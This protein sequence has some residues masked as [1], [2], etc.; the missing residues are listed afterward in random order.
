MTHRVN[1]LLAAVLTVVGITAWPTHLFAQARLF[2]GDNGNEKINVYDPTNGALVKSINTLQNPQGITVG[3]DNRLYAIDTDGRTPHG[4]IDRY[5][6]DTGAYLA[7]IVADVGA[8]PYD[9]MLGPDGKLYVSLGNGTVS[10]YDPTTG[11]PL[12][13][14]GHGGAAFAVGNQGQLISSVFGPDGNLY[15]SDF[16][17]SQVLRFDGTSG[18]LLGVFVS[19][20]LSSPT[21]LRFGP[22]ANLYVGNRGSN[23][24]TRF[25]GTTGAFIDTFVSGS[26]LSQPETFDFGT[27]GVLYV[28]SYANHSI[29]RYN[30]AT[31]AF[32]DV[33][34]S[35]PSCPYRV[36]FITLNP[37]PALAGLDLSFGVVTGGNSVTGT[38][39]LAFAP[40][41]DTIVTLS[42]SVPTKAGVPGTV[43]VS[44]GQ[45]TAT[46]T[47]AT[48][49]VT[50]D[51]P[52]TISAT[53]N[54]VTKTASLVVTPT[55]LLSLTI[56][57]TIVAGGK[58]A[59]GTVKLSKLAPAGGWLIGLSSTNTAASVPASVL[60]AAGSSSARFTIATTLPDLTTTGNISASFGGSTK[61]SPLTVLALTP[62]SLVLTPSTANGGS[63]VSARLTISAAAPV[64]GKSVPL[65][66]GNS[67]ATCPASI[68]VPAGKTSVT[69]S[70]PTIN[71]A[72]SQTGEVS[73][74]LGGV[75]VTAS[76]TVTHV[77]P[78]KMRV[79]FLPPAS[80]YPRGTVI[81]LEAVLKDGSGNPVVGKT[82]RLVQYVQA[83][84]TRTALGSFTTD[85]NGKVQVQNY[86]VPTDPS[87]DNVYIE[88]YFDGE[89]DFTPSKSSKRIP[90][91]T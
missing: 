43:T 13:S 25:N 24:I 87:M 47:V 53:L 77:I 20:N 78:T 34:N 85:A 1:T 45:T 27:D 3:P 30:A 67:A 57:P 55:K 35:D 18:T 40:A 75:T 66:N 69:F 71:P 9:L 86:T 46:F 62:A 42:S 28:G 14:Q 15:C 36:R 41:A 90:I 11:A 91:G 89:G 63:N 59:T 79:D 23:S 17:N 4:A 19:T 81:T 21:D 44:V 68:L 8:Y 83:L 37:V 5:D 12:P 51:T 26:E 2:I 70:I 29:L 76:L 72:T 16:N 88:S 82:L 58:S 54:G 38:V 7:T 73:A 61:T 65:T 49:A 52:I 74:T 60:V 56:S 6:K 33:L 48:S 39:T 31:G 80:R 64:G 50:V 22:D 10:R 84:G 32:M